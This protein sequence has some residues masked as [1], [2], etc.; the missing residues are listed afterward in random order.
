M[1]LPAHAFHRPVGTLLKEGTDTK[2]LYKIEGG[3]GLAR[4]GDGRLRAVVLGVSPLQFCRRPV[5]AHGALGSADLLG[6]LGGMH[7]RIPLVP[8]RDGRRSGR[9]D[10]GG[11]SVVGGDRCWG[12]V[13]GRARRR[14]SPAGRDGSESPRTSSRSG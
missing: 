4:P 13:V 10:L 2:S 9:G 6:D 3:S 7:R 5:P 14:R 1:G 11:V 12:L 8:V